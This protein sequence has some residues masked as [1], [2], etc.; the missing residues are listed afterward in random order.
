MAGVTTTGFKNKTFEEIRTS[1]VLDAVKEEYLGPDMPTTPDSVI[2]NFIN[3]IGAAIKDTWDL[4]QNVLNM[5]NLATAEG[6]YLDNLAALVRVTR[7]TEIGSSGLLE[8]VGDSI[9]TTLVA[10][11]P[12]KDTDG[13]GLLLQ[14][15]I[16]LNKSICYSVTFKIDS[17]VDGATYTISVEGTT[18]S[19]VANTASTNLTLLA[20]LN[21]AI[22]AGSGF[23]STLIETNSQVLIKSISTTNQ[24]T[25]TNSNNMVLHRISAVITAES[26][27]KGAVAYLIGT[28]TNLPTPV[29]GFIS[30]SNIQDFSLGRLR[31]T[32]NE[33]RIR[34]TNVGEASGTGTPPAIKAAL[35]NDVAGVIAVNIEEN[36]TLTAGTLPA[37]SYRVTVSGGTDADVSKKIMETK[38]AT[39]NTDGTETVQVADANGDNQTIKFSRF[40]A[41][42]AWVKIIYSVNPEETFPSTGAVSVQAAVSAKGNLMVPSADLEPTRFYGSAYGATAGMII[43]SIQV[44][45]T[46]TAGGTPS[47]SSSKIVVPDTTTISFD[48]SRVIVSTS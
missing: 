22:Q 26:I 18:Y 20:T 48:P 37:K 16:I 31:E 40:V 5:Q 6:I 15:E 46:S 34:A 1:I 47:Y 43:T 39:A 25:I 12:V 44:A 13:R 11:T 14:K 23:T 9:G 7:L 28:I 17:V 4:Q 33:L 35:L 42:F 24:L 41:E 10:N 19:T 2:G 3:I 36:I 8:V 27:E 21:S 45:K 32:D 30:I 29:A 38:P